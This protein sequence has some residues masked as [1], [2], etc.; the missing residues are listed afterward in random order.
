MHD[1]H[2]AFGEINQNTHHHHSP[3]HFCGE[4]M[5]EEVLLMIIKCSH[6][7]PGQIESMLIQIASQVTPIKFS[8]ASTITWWQSGHPPGS[9]CT[10]RDSKFL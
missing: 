3:L 6:L 9:P 2:A 8:G 1:P 10:D 7:T 4:W 5:R